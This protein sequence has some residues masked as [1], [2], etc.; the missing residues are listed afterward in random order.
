M[1]KPD[2]SN[3]KD[4]N[5]WYGK[6]FLEITFPQFWQHSFD[7]KNN[8]YNYVLMEAKKHIELFNLGKEYLEEYNI[9]DFWQRHCSVCQKSITTNINETCYCSIDGFD[10]ICHD[11]IDKVKNQYSLSILKDVEDIP[12]KGFIVLNVSKAN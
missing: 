11:C 2:L 6:T 7:T 10:W 9:C 8:F 1:Y 4:D 3:K 5:N 12:S